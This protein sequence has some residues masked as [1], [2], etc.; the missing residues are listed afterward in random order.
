MHYDKCHWT[1]RLHLNI[2][3]ASESQSQVTAPGQLPWIYNAS[4]S[5]EY[6][7]GLY[8][9]PWKRIFILFV[10]QYSWVMPSFCC[11]I[12]MC[13][14]KYSLGL[15]TEVRESMLMC[16]DFWG[17]PEGR[18]PECQAA[19]A[20]Q[21]NLTPYSPIKGLEGNTNSSVPWKSGLCIKLTAIFPSLHV[22]T[23]QSVLI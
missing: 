19:V 15:R 14:S 6:L 10:F 16:L 9:S 17:N 3:S 8:V 2:S 13:R 23:I 12:N 20:F 4:I 7:F 21:K 22:D 18:H 1:C 5:R 11:S